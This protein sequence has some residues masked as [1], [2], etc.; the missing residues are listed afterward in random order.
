MKISTY[1]VFLLLLFSS[2]ST[3]SSAQ[4]RHYLGVSGVNFYPTDGETTYTYGNIYTIFGTYSGYG[5][6]AQVHPYCNTMTMDWKATIG[7]SDGYRRYKADLYEVPSSQYYGIY[8]L[9]ANPI[10]TSPT[11]YFNDN[12]GGSY[13]IEL[14][15]DNIAVKENHTYIAVIHSQRR[16][17]GI[18]GPGWTHYTTNGINTI[19]CV[20]ECLPVWSIGQTFASGAQQKYEASNYVV[21][22]NTIESGADITYDGQNYVL[23]TS[24]FHAKQ[25]ATFIAF[26]DGCGGR[27]SDPSPPKG[28]V[29][30]YHQDSPEVADRNIVID[31]AKEDLLSTVKCYPNPATDVV[32]I[33][34]DLADEDLVSLQIRDVSGRVVKNIIINKQQDAGKHKVS[35]E[36]AS[37]A[38]GVYMYVLQTGEALNT[39]K[40]LVQ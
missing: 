28:I 39:G 2:F 31:K 29:Q 13:L 5:P 25:G 36:V 18:W 20:N 1:T 7:S 14:V 17:L 8:D 30:P 15:F 16:R 12:T 21:G 24:G 10:A 40:I 4:A 26:N 32:T 37:F 38:S 6:F 23:L 34:Y 22:F 27:N 3:N 9:P 33:E 35:V 19:N 11:V